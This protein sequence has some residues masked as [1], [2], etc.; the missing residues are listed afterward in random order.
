MTDTLSTIDRFFKIITSSDDRNNERILQ[1]WA[2]L[3]TLLKNEPVSFDRIEVY[4]N[5]LEN[6]DSNT[7]RN[8]NK[9]KKS[10]T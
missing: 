8:V 9:A 6:H 2:Y 7:R 1:E 4:L 5:I 10:L 3:Y